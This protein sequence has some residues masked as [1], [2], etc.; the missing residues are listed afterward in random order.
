MPPTPNK[1]TNAA[2][3]GWEAKFFNFVS[4]ICDYWALAGGL[5]LVGVVLINV[6]TVVGAAFFGKGFPGDFELTEMGVAIAAFSFLPYAQIGGHNVTADIF[7]ARASATVLSVFALLAAAVAL[8]FAGLMTWRNYAGM[9]DQREYEYITAILQIPV[10]WAYATFVISL[11]LLFL[12]A[13]ATLLRKVKTF[14][15]LEL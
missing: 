2:E 7:T 5:V 12:A 1:V 6:F 9:L 14:G 10:W 3:Q 4:R 15:R 13:L 11:A 8:V